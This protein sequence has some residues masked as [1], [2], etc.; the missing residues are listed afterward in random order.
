MYAEQCSLLQVYSHS[1]PLG[2]T[3]V[4]GSH[5]LSRNVSLNECISICCQ[6]GAQ[7]CQ[8]VWM[9]RGY[10]VGLPCLNNK[11]ACGPVTVD[12]LPSTLVSIKYNINIKEGNQ[13]TSGL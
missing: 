4:E 7:L 5:I 2:K 10:C 1:Y 3:K 12:H 6:E 11:T 13:T 8:H 9:L